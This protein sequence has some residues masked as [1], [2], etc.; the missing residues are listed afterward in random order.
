LASDAIHKKKNS[1]MHLDRLQNK[2]K[3][4]K[5]VKITPILGKLMEYKRKWI[6]YVNRMLR[7]I[8]A[9]VVKHYSPTS[10]RNHGRPLK[11]L[12]DT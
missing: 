7:N 12:L 11:R 2:Y 6:E 8:L 3:N 1:R 4:Y 9:R 5:E 10:G